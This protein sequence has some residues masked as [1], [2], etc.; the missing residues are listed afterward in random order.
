MSQGNYFTQYMYM[1]TQRGI[2][3][4]P[5]NTWDM[6]QSND[7]NQASLANGERDVMLVKLDSNNNI[8]NQLFPIE[9]CQILGFGP[10]KTN[11]KLQQVQNPERYTWY[12]RGDFMPSLQTHPEL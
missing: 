1:A 6:Q 10:E 7:L 11:P 8:S 9:Q 2:A 5:S 12:Q 4:L 3:H